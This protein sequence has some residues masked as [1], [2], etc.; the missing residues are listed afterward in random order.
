MFSIHSFGFGTDHDED[1]MTKI[2]Q[3]KEGSF[4]FIKELATLDEAFSN[5]LGGV[6]S[7]VATDVVIKLNNISKNIV[8][9]VKIKRTYGEMWERVNEKE[10]KI[11]I[12]QLMSGISKDY[13]FEIQIPKINTEVGDL[14][15]DHDIL[16]ALFTAKG[17]DGS[18]MSGECCFKITLLN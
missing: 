11:K 15:R 17:V 16:E 8:E 6:I 14:D 4:Y 18:N 9:G 13:V 2:C 3:L 5:A 7:L 10:Y 12:L 1:L